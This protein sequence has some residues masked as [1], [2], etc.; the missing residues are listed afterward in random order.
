MKISWKQLWSDHQ[1][2]IRFF[3]IG[4]WNTIFGYGTYISLDY[5]F[6]MVFQKRY[7]AYMAA[8]VLANIIA[9]TSSF[10][11]HKYITFKSTVRGKGIIIEFVKFYST[12]TVTN[13]L[14]LALL[15][16]FVEVFKIDP[17]IAGALLIPVVAII[18]YFGHSR[19][20]FAKKSE[21]S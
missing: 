2:K 21:N 4:V 10:I 12:Y 5:L 20:S 1:V 14:G 8:A 13:I 16:V 7:V 18:S 19:F 9:T 17:K 15:P 3:I 11:F 6:A